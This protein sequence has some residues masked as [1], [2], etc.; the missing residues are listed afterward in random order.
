MAKWKVTFVVGTEKEDETYDYEVVADCHW[1][2]NA[3]KVG[4]KM[5]DDHQQGRVEKS[6]LRIEVTPAD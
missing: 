1:A 3:P 6:C 5:L 4:F 2:Y